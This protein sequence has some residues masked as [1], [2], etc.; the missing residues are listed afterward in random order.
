MTVQPCDLSNAISKTDTGKKAQRIL[1]YADEIITKW[2]TE[3]EA[4]NNDSKGN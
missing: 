3:M 4:K 2:E 1:Q